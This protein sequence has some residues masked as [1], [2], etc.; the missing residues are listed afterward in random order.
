M[1]VSANY[2]V[3]GN[4][5]STCRTR[6]RFPNY[7]PGM[8]DLSPIRTLERR[9]RSYSPPPPAPRVKLFVS[10]E[11]R[12]DSELNY[13]SETEAQESVQQDQ[14]K[15]EPTVSQIIPPGLSLVLHTPVRHERNT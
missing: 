14:L 5:D 12:D 15:V 10:D 1:S 8:Q 2:A 4:L 11:T 7:P 13:Q 3:T 9:A 6:S